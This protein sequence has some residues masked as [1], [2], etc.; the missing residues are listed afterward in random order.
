VTD[1]AARLLGLLPALYRIR[2]EERGRPLEALLEVLAEQLAVVEHDIDALYENWFIETC[3]PWLVPYIGDLVGNRPIHPVA[4]TERAD[5]AKTISFRRR[6]GT[7]AMLEEMARDVTGWAAHAV[8]TFDLLGWTQHM[9]HPRIT[10][11]R[12]RGWRLPGDGSARPPRDP[13]SSSRVGTA[14]LRDREGLDRLARPFDRM[15]HTVDVRPASTAAG[16]HAIR[17]VVFFLWRLQAYPLEG[18]TPRRS[19]SHAH[20][21]HLDPLGR[22]APLFC[23]AEAGQDARAVAAEAGVPDAIRPLAFYLDLDRYRSLPDAERTGNSDFYGPER[24]VHLTRDGRA[25]PPEEVACMDLSRW[26]PPPP[27]RIGLDVRLGRLTLPEDEAVETQLEASYTYG[28]AADVGGGPYP[29]DAEASTAWLGADVWQVGVSRS[30]TSVGEETVHASL[31]DAVDDWNAQPPGR[32]GIIAILDNASY[33]EALTGPHAIALPEGSRLLIIA[34][35]WPAT[36]DGGPDGRPRRV[37]GSFVPVG[38]RPHL[39]GPISVLG[40][41]SATSTEPGELVLNGLLVEGP[42]RVLVGH[43]GALRLEHCTLDGPSAGLR[44]NATT[45]PKRQNRT[46]RVALERSI[47]G[48]VTLSEGV[49][50]LLLRE[51]VIGSVEAPGSHATVDAATVL[52]TSSV[53]QLD[54]SNSLFRDRVEA[55]RRQVGCV[56]FC[57]LPPDS[58]TP[59]RHRCQ[60]DEAL[61][62]R[63]AALGFDGPASLAPAERERIAAR[64]APSWTSLRHGDPGF[65]QLREGVAREIRAGADDGA[66]MGAFK[67]LLQPQREANLRARLAEYLPAGSEAGLVIV[68]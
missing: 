44:V 20:G 63:A 9:N 23:R 48:P 33:H 68:T 59:P 14:N 4:G 42:L 34:A 25:V 12:G 58:L 57:S 22:D 51:S 52:G 35:H 27:G 11:A 7:T 15:S 38:L 10:P 32:R 62:E 29:R 61:R 43:A 36:G 49:P 54:A 40:T 21:F 41:A 56:R 31:A 19:S 26:A 64:L 17:T 8:E 66:E 30:V 18:V 45:D 46:L 28:F 24:S 1:A 65:A 2:D 39:H 6:K 60:P 53:Q 13:P 47:C 16:W 5:V 67:A 55:R 37:P 3:A 50:S